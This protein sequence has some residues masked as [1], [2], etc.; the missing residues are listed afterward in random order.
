MLNY[1]NSHLGHQAFLTGENLT[2]A[3]LSVAGM[4]T[5]F[6]FAKCPFSRFPNLSKWY[7]GIEALDA[8][9]RSEAELW[10]V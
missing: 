9:Q 1:L 3:D 7:E 6:R 4:M 5:Y 10:K 8:W 2:I